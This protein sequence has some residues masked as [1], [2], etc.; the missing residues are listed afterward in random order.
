M[1]IFNRK[2]RR[3]TKEVLVHEAGQ[4]VCPVRGLVDIERCWMCP[5]YRGLARDVPDG[6]LCTGEQAS[7]NPWAILA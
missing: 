5:A 1:S 4:V 7:V 2:R 6:L 3:P